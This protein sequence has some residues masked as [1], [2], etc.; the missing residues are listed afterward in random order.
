MLGGLDRM[1]AQ[2]RT[3]TKQTDCRKDHLANYPKSPKKDIT[4]LPLCRILLHKI[5]FLMLLYRKIHKILLNKALE[6]LKNVKKLT[7]IPFFETK[8]L[9]LRIIKQ[10][11]Q[12]KPP[13]FYL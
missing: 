2:F 7:K 6:M 8:Y 5:G 3:P 4:Y 13:L 9:P 1:I 12:P 10:V 11:F